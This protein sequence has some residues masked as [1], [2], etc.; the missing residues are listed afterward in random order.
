MPLKSL[1]NEPGVRPTTSTVNSLYV[2]LLRFIAIQE[3]N[4][5]YLE[6]L[7][8][9][10]G[11]S[12]S[13]AGF[14]LVVDPTGAT[15]DLEAVD[16]RTYVRLQ[17]VLA[18]SSPK[19]AA[20]DTDVTATLGSTG[21]GGLTFAGKVGSASAATATI[22][23]LGSSAA[24]TGTIT[25][26]EDV[27]GDNLLDDTITV[28]DGDNTVVFTF[29]SS[30]GAS[31][32]PR[33]SDADYYILIESGDDTDQ[34]IAEAIQYSLNYADTQ[35]NLDI[36]SVWSGGSSNVV[37]LTNQSDGS[38]R[39][40]TITT[41]ADAADITVAGMSGGVSAGT[42]LNGLTVIITDADSNVHT[43]TYSTSNATSSTYIG[44]GSA[45]TV[46]AVATQLTASINAADTSGDLNVT[47]ALNPDDTVALTMNTAGTAGNGDMVTGTAESGGN[48][49]ATSFSGG[50]DGD[51][52]KVA[53]DGD[54]G[55]SASFDVQKADSISLSSNSITLTASGVVSL[56]NATIGGLVYPTSDASSASQALITDGSGTLSF[57]ELR[58]FDKK[59][60]SSSGTSYTH[61]YETLTDIAQ[62]TIAAEA[63][64]STSK[65]PGYSF[66]SHLTTGMGAHVDSSTKAHNIFVKFDDDYL[67]R[68]TN[69]SS[70]DILQLG[71]N[72]TEFD[73]GTYVLVKPSLRGTNS[74][75][76]A[77]TDRAGAVFYDPANSKMHFYTSTAVKE[78]ATA[79]TLSGKFDTSG[80]TVTGELIVGNLSKSTTSLDLKFTDASDSGF[81]AKDSGDGSGK[82]VAFVYNGGSPLFEFAAEGIQGG[83]I[84]DAQTPF[85]NFQTGVGEG[86]TAAKPSYTFTGDDDTGIYRSAAD[87]LSFTAGGTRRASISGAGWD[88][89]NQTIYN[90]PTP[91]SSSH[92][93]TK[94]YIDGIVAEGSSDN[95][96]VAYDAATSKY[97]ETSGFKIPA[98][99]GYQWAEIGTNSSI[100]GVLTLKHASHSYDTTLTPASLMGEALNFTLPSSDGTT[101]SVMV[102]SGSGFLS[103]K[104]LGTLGDSRYV[105]PSSATFTNTV[106]VADG[107]QQAPSIIYGTGSTGSYRSTGQAYATF[108]F[109]DTEYSSSADETLTLVDTSSTSKTYTI[110]ASGAVA[111]SQ[112]FNRGA[113]AS[114]AATNLATLVN[115]S[116]GHNGTINAAAN[117]NAG[118]VEFTQNTGGTAG[119]TSITHSAD[120]DSL[121]DVAPPS[122]FSKG[123]ANES[124]VYQL[125][126][127]NRIAQ[128][129][130]T[131]C[132]GTNK[133]SIQGF[134]DTSG[135]MVTEARSDGG[136]MFTFVSKESS[137]LGYAEEAAVAATGQ[138]T[139]YENT[140]GDNLIGEELDVGDGSNS[141]TFEFTSAYGASG[142]PKDTSTEYR[143][144]IGDVDNDEDIAS[145]I[146]YSINYARG[147]GDLDVQA[148]WSGS[149]ST[150]VTLA[151]DNPGAAG[152]VNI[153]YSGTTSQ[154][155]ISGMSGGSNTVQSLRMHAGSSSTPKMEVKSSEILVDNLQIKGLGAPTDN[156]DASTKLYVDTQISSVIA[157]ASTG[158]A[159]G[160]MMLYNTGTSLPE[161][162]SD[163]VYT[164]DE[165]KI[166]NTGGSGTSSSLKVSTKYEFI[167]IA[168][169]LATASSGTGSINPYTLTLPTTLGGSK[170]V[171]VASDGSGTLTFE[172][173]GGYTTQCIYTVSTLSSN[174]EWHDYRHDMELTL[175]NTP[176]LE[177]TAGKTA[178]GGFV[179][180]V[181][182]SGNTNV[183]IGSTSTFFKTTPSFRIR[184]NGIDLEKG[185]NAYWLSSTKVRIRVRLKAGDVIEVTGMENADMTNMG[186]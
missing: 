134:A 161:F 44:V 140:D 156:T 171:L 18:L 147:E 43:L 178:P 180:T 75:P 41:T 15:T 112:E 163:L 170:D 23:Q 130:D 21:A 52:F 135:R 177:V 129:T 121:C 168:A 100:T 157:P 136:P 179:A 17:D 51:Q 6:G 148:A 2:S 86:T 56:S 124:I 70:G 165:L 55:T 67:F 24:A 92:P 123:A 74:W 176:T 32:N 81:Y 34:D 116:D 62:M 175:N 155:V 80:G 144:K 3:Q 77:N 49:T 69:T 84:S 169:P 150:V 143:I 85:L 172:R 122:A 125:G 7:T 60:R 93:A 141:I 37:S 54:T 31:G 185:G 105:Q 36:T 160:Q 119:N 71:N 114:D 1:V 103:F 131:V 173:R 45:H 8:L 108:T 73:A 110:K 159:S 13:D 33:N 181:G 39:N 90:I 40:I 138:I 104:T 30:Y 164:A 97:V 117:D 127:Y 35:D 96:V 99:G 137:G 98:S 151:N 25:V 38:D 183:E 63:S 65:V 158:T 145:R 91:T 107:T 174:S 58:Q 113:S 115:S 162:T 10:T 142:D 184:V 19:T 5:D 88:F 42:T 95:A 9:A 68:G 146:E 4:N 153:T 76:A 82:A 186:F 59:S 94:S 111:A 11:L 120:W 152:N 79:D 57:T 53:M 83:D 154:I 20:T 118:K 102:T 109:G 89:N 132:E 72:A 64:S 182:Y 50:T 22:T 14:A 139:V 29:K 26:L 12:T 27:E 166:G 126:S 28:E 46:A 48:I 87:T 66:A 61:T 16:Q 128:F 47:A 149:T 78:V 106:V 133:T 167:E 101:D